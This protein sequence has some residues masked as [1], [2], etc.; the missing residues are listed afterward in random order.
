AS[1]GRRLVLTP[2]GSLRVN[3]LHGDAVELLPRVQLPEPGEACRVETS[4]RFAGDAASEKTFLIH[5]QWGSDRAP[6]G[7]ATLCAMPLDLRQGRPHE[8]CLA[9]HLRRS[10]GG[11]RL[12]GTVEARLPRGTVAARAQFAEELEVRQ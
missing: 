7:N 3:T 9:V 12:H 2:G 8:L 4:F 1:E 6:E 10:R 5:L 11:R